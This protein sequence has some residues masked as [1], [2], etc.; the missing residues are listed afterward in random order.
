MNGAVRSRHCQ[1]A[2][3]T[4]R[5]Q[6]ELGVDPLRRGDFDEVGEADLHVYLKALAERRSAR[7]D[8][9]IAPTA[10]VVAATQ[11]GTRGKKPRP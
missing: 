10:R 8:M 2:S 11:R 7:L 3:A 1:N 5:A 4:L 6:L 9:T